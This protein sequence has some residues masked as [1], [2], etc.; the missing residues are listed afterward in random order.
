MRTGWLLLLIA[1]EG[2][3]QSPFATGLPAPRPRQPA[4]ITLEAPAQR[5]L[6]SISG[7]IPQGKPTSEPLMLTIRD[8]IARGLKYNLAMVETGESVQVRRAERLRAL[9][10]LLPTLS[11]RPSISEQ[12]TNLAAFGFSG[13]PGIPT[14]VGPFTIY[15]ARASATQSLLNFQN[16]RNLRAARE[17]SRAAEFSSRDIREEVVLAVTGLY[18]QAVAGLARIEAQRAQVATAD[19]AHRQAVDRKSAGTVA[20]IDVLRAQVELQSEQQR[21]Y[22]YEGE[23]DK[24]KLD[25]ARAIGLPPGQSIELEAM[26]PYVP[27]PSAVTLE[28]SLDLAFKQRADY[29][30]AES[31]VRA[32][33]LAKGAA[34]AGRL[35]TADLNANYGVIGPSLTQMHG[36]FT[37]VGGVDIPL[38]QGGRVKAE[39]ELADSALRQRKAELES[40]RGSIDADVRRSLTDVRS[41]ERR[42]QVARETI[43]LS[44]QELTQAQDRFAA[45]VAN[46]LEVV[47]AQQSVAAANDNYISSLFAFNAA[48][49]AL[50]RAQGDAERSM[51]E[52][53]GRQK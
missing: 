17:P 49:A 13:F 30:A 53:L 44:K 7:S 41:S 10:T 32:A 11:V 50:I 9:S 51:G 31:R 18:L 33:E 39:V 34:Q 42:V 36:S 26:P 25:L 22:Y 15:D 1:S 35:P 24:Q 16:L 48:K 43:E 47:Q 5:P 28:S 4:S 38:F 46:N 21:L 19:T 40:L 27:L 6:G 23:F 37:V 14:I 8:A 2:F 20:G 29:R 3:A 12:Q 45:G 52:I